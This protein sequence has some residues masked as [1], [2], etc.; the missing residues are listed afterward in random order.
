[1]RMLATAL[2]ILVAASPVSV[3]AAEAGSAKVFYRF[4]NAEGVTVMS[5]AVTAEAIA[6]G[7][8]EVTAHG[9]VLRRVERAPTPEE[10]KDRSSRRAQQ[11][12][13]AEQK[14]YDESLLLRY[15]TVA[16]IESA[17]DRTLADFDNRISILRGNILANKQ[18][19][20]RE[21]ARAADIERAGRPLPDKLL[22]G[23]DA[24]KQ[25]IADN[26][27]LIVE[28]EQEKQRAQDNFE[29]DIERFRYLEQHVLRRGVPPAEDTP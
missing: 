19:V 9:T 1:M 24:L 17:R 6:N 22:K 16:D 18:Q 14:K 8:E 13:E 28:R 29:S 2:L 23:I 7:Y 5:S 12:R 26:E 10:L 20:E 3:W 4:K 25:D 15:S 21:L 27:A 11:L